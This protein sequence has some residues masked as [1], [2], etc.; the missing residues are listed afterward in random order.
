MIEGKKPNVKYIGKHVQFWFFAP[1]PPKIAAEFSMEYSQKWGLDFPVCADVGSPMVGQGPDSDARNK[2]EWSV[3][4][5]KGIDFYAVK[6][7]TE[8]LV[9]LL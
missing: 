1:F 5:W 3:W 9:Q 7:E 2:G 8:E 6:Q 4:K